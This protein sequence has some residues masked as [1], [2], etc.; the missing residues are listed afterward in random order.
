MNDK[1]YCM[2][3]KYFREIGE[4]EECKES[5]ITT[6]TYKRCYRT[7]TLP[8]TKNRFNDCESFEKKL[9]I[10]IFEYFKRI[11]RL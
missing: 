10:I 7:Y 6:I 4:Y 9:S 5:C 1:V 11:L 3:C 8:R 2:D